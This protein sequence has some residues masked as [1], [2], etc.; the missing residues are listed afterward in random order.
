LGV[1]TSAV[2][3]SPRGP[4]ASALASPA[5]A[6]SQPVGL[7]SEGGEAPDFQLYLAAAP[8]LAGPVHGSPAT[9][10]VG[11]PA[12]MSQGY[13]QE[14]LFACGR[15]AAQT[16]VMQVEGGEFETMNKKSIA[17]SA[18]VL[19]PAKASRQVVGEAKWLRLLQLNWRRA[20]PKLNSFK[21][22][23][24]HLSLFWRRLTIFAGE[25]RTQVMVEI[26]RNPLAVRQG[27]ATIMCL[28]AAA[29]AMPVISHRA[30][31]QRDGAEWA[32]TSNAFQA[33]LEQSL[34]AGSDPNARVE[35]VAFR[36]SDGLRAR[37]SAPMLESADARAIMLQAVLRGPS[38]TIEQAAPAE[39]AIDQRQHNC[40]SQAIY[41][42]ARGETQQGQVAVAEV[43]I[44]RSRSRAY[45]S[46]ICG[47]VYQGSHLST[48]CQFTFTCDGSLGQRPRG[49]AWD[50]AQ[51][52]ATAVMLGYTRPLTNNA[53]HY[54][55]TAVNPVWNSGL[56]PT[57]KI[58][59]HQFYRFPRGA[60]RAVYQEA[61]ARRLG[62]RARRNAGETL[63]PEADDAALDAVTTDAATTAPADAPVTTAP[64]TPAADT[65]TEAAV[66]DDGIPT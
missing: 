20:V 55:T 19:Y 37:G 15:S 63:I 12:R 59:V 26:D 2:A 23:L 64:A 22:G 44:N 66:Q 16:E 42:E 21:R 58:G 13:A 32:A 4:S 53:T 52:V 39:A 57:T 49:R 46:S 50:R 33:Q 25:I 17:P 8:M 62:A 45:P 48:G 31:E 9:R 7:A 5:P 41:Y 27:A 28:A 34:V 47:V 35:L 18:Q 61:Q 36:T 29:V 3:V 65:S 43:I 51:R 10:L 1:V 14:G 38:A 56:V 30:A 11:E 24:M 6:E 54:H 60:E 40:L